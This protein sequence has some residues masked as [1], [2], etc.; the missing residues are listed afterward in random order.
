MPNK[1][2]LTRRQFLKA[3]GAGAVVLGAGA[4]CGKVAGVPLEMP[5]EYLPEGGPG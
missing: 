1:N 3:A 2:K 4:G 5:D